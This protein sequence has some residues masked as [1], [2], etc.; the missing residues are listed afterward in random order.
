[1]ESSSTSSLSTGFHPSHFENQ[2]H[3]ASSSFNHLP[4]QPPSLP[5][6]NPSPSSK[7]TSPYPGASFFVGGAPSGSRSP[8]LNAP[9]PPSSPKP[10]FFSSNG[11][12]KQP[13]RTDSFGA[14]GKALSGWMMRKGSTKKAAGGSGESLNDLEK[15]EQRKKTQ[16]PTPTTTSTPPRL[17]EFDSDEASSEED[18]VVDISWARKMVEEMEAD[19]SSSSDGGPAMGAG[20]SRGDL[21][22]LDSEEDDEPGG[23]RFPPR[24]SSSSSGSSFYNGTPSSA[25]PPFELPSPS[26]TTYSPSPASPQEPLSPSQDSEITPRLAQFSHSNP[27]SPSNSSTHT[28]TTENHLRHPPGSP[29]APGNGSSNRRI[30]VM[31]AS[32]GPSPSTSSSSFSDHTPPPAPRMSI[33]PA[34]KEQAISTNLAERRGLSA[35][36]LAFVAP[37]DASRRSIGE[38]RDAMD[39]YGIKP[40]RRESASSMGGGGRSAPA[41]RTNFDREKESGVVDLDEDLDDETL[42]SSLRSTDH[43]PEPLST[44]TD[45]STVEEDTD[46][47]DEASPRR[48]SLQS[49]LREPGTSSP[50]L[51]A[52]R[53]RARKARSVHL[54]TLQS[55]TP[56]PTAS[57]S[58][59]SSSSSSSRPVLSADTSSAAFLKST[60]GGDSPMDSGLWTPAIGEGKELGVGVAGPQM[61]G[62]GGWSGRGGGGSSEGTNVERPRKSDMR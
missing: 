3:I 62:M 23:R 17:P 48:P 46:D 16:S 35:S 19:Q 4:L 27:P 58:A 11:G 31:E 37:P 39:E 50:A 25:N 18:G 33:S 14:K 55:F 6:N 52:A 10:S 43:T 45:L 28:T 53:E 24:T 15:A 1:M 47:P 2:S 60:S 9:S 61:L 30:A 44:A 34:A 38:L 21:A 22:D 12:V 5:L 54:A 26:R 57:T 32:P 51:Q 8:N 41:G 59:S 56:P 13:K 29:F 49:H 42:R 7:P 36:R 20:S 40:P